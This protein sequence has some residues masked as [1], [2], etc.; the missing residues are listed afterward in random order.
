MGY[1]SQHNL[2]ITCNPG[3]H[4][5]VVQEL[6]EEL[7][8][9]NV[10]QTIEDLGISPHDN[11]YHLFACTDWIHWYDSEE[12]LQILSAKFPEV[13]LEET[14]QGENYDDAWTTY[15]KGGR[16]MADAQE[17]VIHPFDETKLKGEPPKDLNKKYSCQAG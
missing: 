8:K 9:M 5:T 15:F 14:G 13:L 2:T 7:G 6:V 3:I 11:R 4:C 1:D 12:D 17:V 10:F 16:Y